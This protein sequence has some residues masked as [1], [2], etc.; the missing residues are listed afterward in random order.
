MKRVRTV[1]AILE[2]FGFSY[3]FIESKP[4]VAYVIAED[5]SLIRNGDI[6]LAINGTSLEHLDQ[7][8][9]CHYFLHRIESNQ[10][11]IN[12]KIDRGG[13]VFDYQIERKV[14]LN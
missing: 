11:T 3:R 5:E 6:I 13:K 12:I 2:S 4:V 7:D 9:V 14:Y 8:K 10:A 1:P